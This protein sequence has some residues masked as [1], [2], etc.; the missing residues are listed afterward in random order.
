[1]ASQEPTPLILFSGLAADANIFVPQKIVFP[2]LIVPK[3]PRLQPSDTLD[4]YCDRLAD[5]LNVQADAVIGGASFGGIIALH[6]AQRVNPGAVI[7]IGSV[8]SPRELPGFVRFFRPLRPLVALLPVRLMQFCCTPF[9]S[10]MARR[11]SPLTSALAKQF[12]GSEPAVIKWSLARILDWKGEPTV[13]C[14]VFQIQGDR[15]RLLPMR[16]TKPDTV[17]TGGGHLISLTHSREVN[18]FIH[19]VISE[20]RVA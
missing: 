3:W 8:R 9:A 11:W 5:E 15:D 7:L 13:S 16:F 17:V 2:Q 12:C 6:V 19:S 20:V 14:P 18:E 4:S 1:M 10:N